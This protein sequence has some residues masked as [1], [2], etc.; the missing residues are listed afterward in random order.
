MNGDFSDWSTETLLAQDPTGDAVGAFDVT[1]LHVTSRASKLYVHFRTT[2]ILNL[3]SGPFSDGSLQL[4]VELP[5]TRVLTVDF[6][7]REV[8]LTSAGALSSYDLGY[9]ASP[10]HAGDAFEL[11]FDLG[12]L[13]VGLGDTIMVGL[14]GADDIEPQAFTLRYG[15]P[16]PPQ[17]LSATPPPQTRVRLAS[18]NTY[19]AGLLDDIR[20]PAFKRLL[21]AAAADVYVLQE[22]GQTPAKFLRKTFVE[23]DPH[24]DGAE[25]N[26]LSAGVGNILGQRGGCA[27]RDHPHH[28]PHAAFHRGRGE[29]C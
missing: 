24:E 20:R 27:R 16:A 29:A 26:V 8:S 1:E 19:R 7:E 18:L 22:L 11:R 23:A 4:N 6:R 17:P 2:D 15:E 25:W 5:D 13:G 12:T 3:S 14:S 10:T 21:R 9:L 28:H